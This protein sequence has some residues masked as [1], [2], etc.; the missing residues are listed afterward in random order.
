MTGSLSVPSI[1]VAKLD[2]VANDLPADVTALLDLKGYPTVKLFRADSAMA[3]I[4]Y[5][6]RHQFLLD[7]DFTYCTLLTMG[8]AI[9]QRTV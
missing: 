4:N 3:P 2:K 5:N 6:V 1:A 7:R 8:R 9:G